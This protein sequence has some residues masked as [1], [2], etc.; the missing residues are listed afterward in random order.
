M[1]RYRRIVGPPH[2][3]ATAAWEVVTALITD[4][5]TASTQIS[6]T[7]VVTALTSLNGLGAALIAAGHLETTP[8]VLVSNGL[9]VSITVATGADSVGVEENI[10]PVP[11]GSTAT[12]DWILHLPTPAPLRSILA[13][14]A[15][16]SSHL[17]TDPAPAYGSVEASTATAGSLVDL[18]TLDDFQVSQ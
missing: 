18:S 2:R 8:L 16:Q 4:T 3:P 14:A 13:A 9:H 7:D 6:T 10:N 5:L 11:G 15:K 12:T 1:Q 17:S